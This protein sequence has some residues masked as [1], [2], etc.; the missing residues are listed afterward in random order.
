VGAIALVALI[1][2]AVLGI[3]ILLHQDGGSSNQERPMEEW[4]TTVTATGDDG[5]AREL[6]V[7]SPEPGVRSTPP[8]SRS[9][10]T[11]W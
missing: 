10:S 3:P 9:A 11:S 5:R 4:P 2:A 6:T 8:R 7:L 1:P